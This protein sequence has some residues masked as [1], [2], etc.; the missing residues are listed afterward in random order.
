MVEKEWNP[1]EYIRCRIATSYANL[2]A[3]KFDPKFD[4]EAN[5]YVHLFENNGS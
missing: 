3:T 1:L 5:T 4:T 2:P